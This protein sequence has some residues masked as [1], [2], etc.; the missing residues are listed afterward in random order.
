MALRRQRDEAR[1]SEAIDAH[2]N[3]TQEINRRVR[4]ASQMVAEEV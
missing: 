3:L 1:L 2:D 4:T